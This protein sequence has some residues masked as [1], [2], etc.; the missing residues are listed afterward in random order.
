MSIN[1]NAL[2]KKWRTFK[3]AMITVRVSW[4]SIFFVFLTVLILL[5]NSQ[6]KDALISMGDS[7]NPIIFVMFTLRTIVFAFLVWYWARVM[8][9]VRYPAH[10]HLLPVQKKIIKYCPRIL[11]LVA[12]LGMALVLF[13]VVIRIDL[14]TDGK[15]H[16]TILMFVFIAIAVVFFL[17]VTFRRNL[18]P[19]NSDV[20]LKQ[21]IIKG[22]AVITFKKLPH[23][24]KVVLLVTTII[25]GIGLII[26]L[27]NPIASAWLIV[28]TVSII[29]IC[30][31]IWLSLLYWITY[32]SIYI[33]FPIAI[34]IIAAVCIFSFINSNDNI[35]TLD[36]ALQQTIDD[37]E[38]F[39][40]DLPYIGLTLFSDGANWWIL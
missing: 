6:A 16:L 28:D 5:L 7:Q 17:F 27:I 39:D 32:W 19:I 31:S 22:K 21:K 4:I 14:D 35:V 24:T 30:F 34:F 36:P 38:T 25:M 8:Y 26:F 15:K 10:V 13:V 33:R 37:C 3:K 12:L 11:G 40:L 20:R 29:V 18:F 9:Y 2:S 1:D 23:I